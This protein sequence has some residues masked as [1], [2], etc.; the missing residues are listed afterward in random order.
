MCGL[1]L[2]LALGGG[3]THNSCLG[4]GHDVLGGTKTQSMRTSS[5]VWRPLEGPLS[6]A[7]RLALG[8]RGES[9][10]HVEAREGRIS[11]NHCGTRLVDLGQGCEIEVKIPTDLESDTW[12][13]GPGVPIRER[14]GWKPLLRTLTSGGIWVLPGALQGLGLEDAFGVGSK[15]GRS[16]HLPH[17]VGGTPYVRLPM[18]VFVRARPSC[19]ATH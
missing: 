4:H 17:S 10:V 16:W 5:G 11:T 9:E 1:C 7:D 19:R 6:M 18:L 14:W 15:L 12:S 8:H 3:H 2:L 13:P